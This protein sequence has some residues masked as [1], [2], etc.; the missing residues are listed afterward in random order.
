VHLYKHEYSG[1]EKIT[2][3][4]MNKSGDV[5][6]RCSERLRTLLTDHKNSQYVEVEETFCENEVEETIDHELESSDLMVSCA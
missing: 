1:I 2:K 3:G 6:K 4:L 5:H